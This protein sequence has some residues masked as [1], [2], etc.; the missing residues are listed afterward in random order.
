MSEVYGYKI[1]DGNKIFAIADEDLEREDR[2][3]TSAVHFLRFPISEQMIEEMST[4]AR[5]MMGVQ[6]PSCQIEPITLAE[7][8]YQSLLMDM[9]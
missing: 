4:G 7:R 8:T 2:D 6:H 9:N 5:I 3:K 1:G